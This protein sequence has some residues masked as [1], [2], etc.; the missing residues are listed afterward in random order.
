MNKKLLLVALFLL[1]IYSC[2]VQEKSIDGSYLLTLIDNSTNVTGKFTK[3]RYGNVLGVIEWDQ[4]VRV[5][6][7]NRGL[8]RAE[9]IESEDYRSWSVP[10]AIDMDLSMYLFDDGNEIRCYKDMGSGNLGLFS[11]FDPVL[12][13]ME[14][15]YVAYNWKL[16]GQVSMNVL[17]GRLISTGRVRGNQLKSRGGWGKDLPDFPVVENFPEVAEAFAA[18]PYYDAETYLKDRRGIS[19]HKSDSSKDWQNSILSDPAEFYEKGFRGWK[20]EDANGIADFYA[21]TLVDEERILIKVFWKEKNR[22]IDRSKYSDQFSENVR[23]RFR[24]TG[25]TTIIPGVIK[26]GELKIASTESVIPL[27]P[28]KRVVADEVH[29]ASSPGRE[30]VGQ[31]SLAN[32][33]LIN[34]NDVY[35]FFQYRDDVHYEYHESMNYSGIFVYK[36][37]KKEFNSL[38]EE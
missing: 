37:D 17:N 8:K 3:S 28:F 29:W 6:Y 19:I 15:D 27:E 5:Y 13:C 22:L 26:N 36:M 24:F 33:V 20:K 4:K 23:R 38:F 21:S 31:F 35:L 7:Q 12:G 9:Y 18:F 1:L 25:E 14:K 34:E 16:D 2:S 10:V 32:R 11:Q 30:E